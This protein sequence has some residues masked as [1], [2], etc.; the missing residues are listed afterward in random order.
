MYWSKRNDSHEY[1]F[2]G[3]K[4]Y[5]IVVTLEIISMYMKTVVTFT[6]GH[7]SL[8]I[9]LHVPD[10]G[11]VSQQYKKTKPKQTYRL[12]TLSWP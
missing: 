7:S 1:L 5:E 8:A 6:L 11:L 2:E 9:C 12:Q 4:L 3:V 10:S